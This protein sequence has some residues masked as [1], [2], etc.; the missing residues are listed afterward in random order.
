M[1]ALW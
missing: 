1:E